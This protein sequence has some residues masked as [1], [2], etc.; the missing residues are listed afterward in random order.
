MKVR[1]RFR[2]QKYLGL[3]RDVIQS[4]LYGRQF[5]SASRPLPASVI[6][7]GTRQSKNYISVTVD[8][9][10]R[11]TYFKS[12]AHAEAARARRRLASYEFQVKKF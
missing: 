1:V 5:L 11:S 10:C 3:I 12:R 6:K 8:R 7:F 2:V 4:R 9:R